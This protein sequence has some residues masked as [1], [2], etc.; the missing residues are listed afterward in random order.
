MTVYENLLETLYL[1]IYILDRVAEM[2][3]K[4]VQYP[5]LVKFAFGLDLVDWGITLN[6]WYVVKMSQYSR[7]FGTGGRYNDV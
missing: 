7:L 1:G 6:K 3:T 2:E 5:M 4:I